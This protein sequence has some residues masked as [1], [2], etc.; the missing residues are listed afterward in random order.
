MTLLSKSIK[1]LSKS[2]VTLK[3]FCLGKLP[4]I[5]CTPEEDIIVIVKNLL[6]EEEWAI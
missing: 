5:V 3:V 6:E 1:P 2:D 4:I